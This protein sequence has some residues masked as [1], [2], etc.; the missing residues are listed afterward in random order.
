VGNFLT[1]AR[2]VPTIAALRHAPWSL[3]KVKTA[4]RCGLEFQY[5]Y[6]DRIPERAVEG[7]AR[8]GKAIHAALEGVLGRAPVEEVLLKNR[9]DLLHDEERQKYDELSVSV[10]KFVERIETFRS[11]R[12]VRSQLV[13]HMVAVNADL[14]STPFVAK[15]AFFRGVWDAGFV[16]DEGNL[17]VVD[18]KTGIRRELSDYSD[19]LDGY[20]I[21]AAANLQHVRQVW[22][23]VHFVADAAMEWTEPV[24]LDDVKRTV[25]QRVVGQ[26]EEAAGAVASGYEPRPSWYCG[27]CAYRAICPVMRNKPAD[28]S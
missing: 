8:V 23:G 6:V 4:L 14:E 26:I 24:A 15:D 3:S 18:H 17:A 20:A 25:A 7:D 2:R 5:R 27:R 12:R 1:Y 13:E 28:E 11:R 9:Q 19:Q 21:L 10:R 16:Y 22:L